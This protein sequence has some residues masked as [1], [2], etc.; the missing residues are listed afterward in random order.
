VLVHSPC[1][2][3]RPS[4]GGHPLTAY[5]Q[6]SVTSFLLPRCPVVYRRVPSSTGVYRRLP[7]STVASVVSSGLPRW[8]CEVSSRKHRVRVDDRSAWSG[9]TVTCQGAAYANTVQVKLCSTVKLFRAYVYSGSLLLKTTTLWYVIVFC[10]L[11]YL[12][13]PIIIAIQP[14]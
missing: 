14:V 2:R 4:I 10:F 5:N 12:L 3:A 6:P 9:V 1:D 11:V 8:D 13:L 7:A